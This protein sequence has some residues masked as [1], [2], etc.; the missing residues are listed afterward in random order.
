VTIA[1]AFADVVCSL[2]EAVMPC[3][4]G[5]AMSSWYWDTKMSIRKTKKAPAGTNVLSHG[6][7]NVVFGAITTPIVFEGKDWRSEFA[8]EGQLSFLEW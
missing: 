5:S 6:R 4:W 3:R 8:L 1:F 7:L 2:E